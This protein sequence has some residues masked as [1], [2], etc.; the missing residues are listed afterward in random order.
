MPR[1]T[2][3]RIFLNITP[4]RTTTLLLLLWPL[5]LLGGCEET[6]IFLATEAGVDAVK[7]VTLSDAQVAQ[8]ARQ[9]A[10]HTDAENRVAAPTNSYAQRLARLVDDHKQEQ[11][12]TFNYKV[13]LDPTINAFAMA[14]G[15]I[16]IYSGLMDMMDDGELRFVI[17]H[18]MGHV[19]EKHIKKGG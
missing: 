9:A 15:T 14:D 1:A 19:L 8:I 12:I 2:R 10:A 5:L 3:C 16:R 4:W 11:G 17:G 13:Y 6:N 7:A 18:E